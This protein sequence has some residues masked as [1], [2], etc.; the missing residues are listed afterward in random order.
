MNS[1]PTDIQNTR[2][3]SPQISTTM[4]NQ[5]QNQN[6]KIPLACLKSVKRRQNDK[7]PE[8]PSIAVVSSCV[9]RSTSMQTFENIVATSLI[10][11][12]EEQQKNA[13]ENNIEVVYNLTMFD[14]VKENIYEKKNI[15]D[16]SLTIDEAKTITRPRGMT[17]LFATAIA[18]L[19]SLRRQINEIKNTPEAQHKDVKGIFYLFTDGMDN[20][21]SPLTKI[22]LQS[23]IKMAEDDG[24]T[25]IFAAA[26]QDALASGGQYGF[27]MNNCLSMNSE[28]QGATMGLRACSQA[29]GRAITG[30][31]VGFT[32]LERETSVP[33]PI[34]QTTAHSLNTF[35][36]S[37]HMQIPNTPN[38]TPSSFSPGLHSPIRS[39]PFANL[40]IQ[41][42]A[43][44]SPP[45]VL[46]RQQTCQ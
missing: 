1:Q 23:A 46:I 6:T 20:Q 43:R 14:T 30:Q 29:V 27:N 21:S 40:S 18:E 38:V 41:I 13:K 37:P 45:S 44:N 17:K 42:P 7:R 11:F 26:N 19:A 15:H 25:C 22:D 34:P 4:Q 9:D 3:V 39:P 2:A 33:I 36:R 32:Q 8:A 12:I 28:G 16:I 24:I 35:M 5:S 31:N 10:E